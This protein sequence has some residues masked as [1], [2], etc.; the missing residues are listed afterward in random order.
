MNRISFLNFQRATNKIIFNYKIEISEVLETKCWRGVENGELFFEFNVANN[1]SEDAITV[2]LSC[3]VGVLKFDEVHFDCI[4]HRNTAQKI[5]KFCKSKITFRTILSNDYV[6]S[7]EEKVILNFSGGLDSLASLSL[8][9]RNKLR[10]VSIEFGG[11]FKRESDFFTKFDPFIVKTNFRQLPF[12]KKLESKNWQFMGVGTI[13]FCEL[14]K[15]KYF[16][17]GSILE[18]DPNLNV[19]VGTKIKP[20]DI[21]GLESINL[22]RGMTELTTTKIACNFQDFSTIQASLNSLSDPGSGKRFRKDLLVYV[23]NPTIKINRTRTTYE[24][25]KDYT[26]DFLL[27]YIIKKRGLTFSLQFVKNIPPEIV[28]LVNNLTL[29][30]YERV[31][32]CSLVGFPTTSFMKYFLEKI[33]SNNILFYEPKDF[34]ELSEVRNVLAEFYGQKNN[35]ID[36]QINYDPHKHPDNSM[37]WLNTQIS[38]LSKGLKALRNKIIKVRK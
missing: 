7:F 34:Q 31:H 24:F 35:H 26:F 2:A 27:L 9:E 25:G 8:I 3:I 38:L 6:V 28:A 13:L 4:V 36:F 22:V 11:N 29:S 21:L 10:L 37:S 20:F 23:F 19:K 17:F 1:P 12:F 33:M 30:F 32:P 16:I 5:K 18:A 14:L 15:A